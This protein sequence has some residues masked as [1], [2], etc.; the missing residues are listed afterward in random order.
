MLSPILHPPRP[1][2]VFCGRSHYPDEGNWHGGVNY[3]A[4]LKSIQ[5]CIFLKVSHINLLI[6][7]ITIL[8]ALSVVYQWITSIQ[9]Y[10]SFY[11][12]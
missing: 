4:D 6:L 9:G 12:T 5:Y 10:L 11:I 7:V 2:I 1:V 8:K 3:G